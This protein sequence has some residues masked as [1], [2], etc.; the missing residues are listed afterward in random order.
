MVSH[1]IPQIAKQMQRESDQITYHVMTMNKYHILEAA[2]MD[3]D[4]AYFLYTP[5]NR[6]S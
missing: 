6:L 4:D 5:K 3:D 2:G 1:T